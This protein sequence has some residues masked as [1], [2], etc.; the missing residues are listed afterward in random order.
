ME[1]EYSLQNTKQQEDAVLE[2]HRTVT[3]IVNDEY[4]HCLDSNSW[5]L[6]RPLS[7]MI[8]PIV[9]LLCRSFQATPGFSGVICS[10]FPGS[11]GRNPCHQG[12]LRPWMV[13]CVGRMLAAVG[14]QAACRRVRAGR[15]SGLSAPHSRRP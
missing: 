2:S 10:A 6:P 1:T 8:A 7:S 5:P 4:V 3:A 15:A 9:D 14:D 13:P 11:F 12:R